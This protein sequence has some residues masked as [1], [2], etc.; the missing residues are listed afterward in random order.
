MR[1]FTRALTALM[2]LLSMQ[3]SSTFAQEILSEDFATY[4]GNAPDPAGWNEWTG[5]AT[6]VDEDSHWS[7][8][9]SNYISAEKSAKFGF[10][11][12]N[13]DPVDAWL[14]SPTLDLTQ[15]GGT[16]RLSFMYKSGKLLGD[17]DYIEVKISVDNGATFSS[18]GTI[19]MG[20]SDGWMQKIVDLSAYN[21][22]D[23]RL[24]FYAHDDTEED[25][26]TSFY[27]DNVVVE[28]IPDYDYAILPNSINDNTFPDTT[29]FSGDVIN[30]GAALHSYGLQTATTPVRWSVDGGSPATA[31]ETSASIDYLNTINHTFA[32][33]WTAP[34]EPGIY[35]LKLYTDHA[36]DANR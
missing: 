9:A 26:Y 20:S 1:F 15:N 13:S 4:E 25:V 18:L 6:P 22:T 33:G 17:N 19:Q 14:L 8:D 29:V 24:A 32:S 21:Q 30:F 12:W 23:V 36:D 27:I 31:N 28:S 34:N 2:L 3:F 5:V 7:A 10:N 11:A 16:N 35:T